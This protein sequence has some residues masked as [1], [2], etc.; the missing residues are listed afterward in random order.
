M[1]SF[2]IRPHASPLPPFGI[3]KSGGF[4]PDCRFPCAN[5]AQDLAWLRCQIILAPRA[6]RVLG[7]RCL[8]GPVASAILGIRSTDKGVGVALTGVRGHLLSASLSLGSVTGWKKRGRSHRDL[9]CLGSP[10]VTFVSCQPWCPE[11]RRE[12]RGEGRGHF[13]PSRNRSHER[14][15]ISPQPCVA[16][17][18]GGI[19]APL[20]SDPR[21]VPCR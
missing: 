4:S 7:P 2:S 16:T 12:M 17:K 19:M 14:R 15:R 11:C 21:G 18:A 5:L 9:T 6:M 20:T 3:R 13:S 1:A 8:M 10:A